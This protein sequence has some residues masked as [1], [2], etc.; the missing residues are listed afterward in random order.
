MKIVKDQPARQ[1]ELTYLIASD[2]TET[3]ISK[4]QQ[5]VQDLVKKH[6]GK[7]IETE[8]WGKKTLAYKLKKAGKIFTT[9]VYTHLV[10]ELPPG[11][12]Q[13]LEKQLHLTDQIIRHLLITKESK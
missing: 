9:A 7:I 6:Q 5:T 8:D 10:I 1:Y 2:L 13:E 12:A 3:E 11:Q 4:L